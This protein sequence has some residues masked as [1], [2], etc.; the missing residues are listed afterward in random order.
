MLPAGGALSTHTDTLIVYTAGLP[1]VFTAVSLRPRRHCGQP[2]L[3]LDFFF[4]PTVV[5][6][7]SFASD[8]IPSLTNTTGKT[9]AN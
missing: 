8:K 7:Q 5:Q 1:T 6:A 4:S 2:Q 3:Q 9:V